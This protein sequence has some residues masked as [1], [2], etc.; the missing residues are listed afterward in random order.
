MKNLFVIP[1]WYPSASFPTSGIFFKE[2]SELIARHRPD[3]KV[4]ISTWGSHDPKYW[5]LAS[6][7]LDAFTKYYSR[8]KIRQYEYLLEPNCVELFYPAFTWTR[9][10]WGGNIEGIIAANEKNLKRFILHFGKPDIIHAHV[11]Y[12]AGYIA[13]QLSEKYDIPFIVTEH[14]SPFP[15]S[16]LGSLLRKRLIPT[17]NSAQKVLAVGDHLVERLSEYGVSA[18]KTNNFIDDEFFSCSTNARKNQKVVYLAIGRLEPQKDF[19]T[20]LQAA[21]HLALAGEVFDLRIIGEGSERMKL[22]RLVRKLN[23]KNHVAFLGQCDRSIVRDELQRCDALVMSSL[24]E[25]QPVS[26]IESLACGKPVISTAW[27]GAS[28]MVTSEVGFISPLGDPKAL[29]QNMEQVRKASIPNEQVR[30]YF[31]RKY[32][33]AKAVDALEQVYRGII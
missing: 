16:S 17:L 23:L 24:H 10:I 7:P 33:C 26:I 6:R 5:M 12:P 20:L 14:M 2:Q 4:G 31:N 13:K 8:L 30:G 9:K 32:S 27:K 22:K 28:E 29:A 25:N 15:M 11:A 18:H 19:E 1:S 21:A 3:W